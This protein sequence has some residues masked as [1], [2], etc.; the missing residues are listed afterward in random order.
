LVVVT[1]SSKK[2]VRERKRMDDLDDDSGRGSRW[3]RALWSREDGAA[4]GRRT[5]HASGGGGHRRGVCG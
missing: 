3:F 5:G 4:D 1:W 2:T